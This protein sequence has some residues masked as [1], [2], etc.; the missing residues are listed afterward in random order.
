MTRMGKFT[1]VTISAVALT[2]VLAQTASATS[3]WAKKYGVACTQCHTAFPRLN[4]YGERFMRN[5]YQDPD[6]DVADGNEM[7]KKQINDNLYVDRVT[8]LFGFRLNVTPFGWKA[9][10]LADGGDQITLGNANWIQF[11]VAGSIAKNISFFT[12][13]EFEEGHA[14]FSWYKLRFTNLAGSQMANVEVGNLSPRDYGCYPN[15][16]RIMGPV[17]GDIFGVGSSGGATTPTKALMKESAGN[18]SSAR[19]GVQYYGYKGPVIVWAGVSPGKAIGTQNT[20]VDMD[21]EFNYWGGLRCNLPVAE[22]SAFEGSG[23]SVWG[24]EGTDTAAFGGPG[25]AKNKYS[26]YSVESTIRW[27]SLDIMAAYARGNDDNWNLDATN[28]DID[29]DGVSLVGGYMTTLSNGKGLYYALE[30]DKVMSSD[31]SSLEAEYI[32]PSIS[33]FPIDN[34][35]IGVYARI[36]TKHSSPNSKS[37]A[38][39]NIRTMF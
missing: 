5:G 1:T 36:D 32:T 18:M 8:N 30:Y 34:M 2:M 22:D 35:R 33:Y 13:M 15:R 27:N 12:E 39:M 14:K 26:R 24:L 16:L 11:F 21:S 25:E 29:Y 9:N 10:G 23:I 7:G 3:Q 31:V 20:G 38:F 19:P 4:S 37:T 17:K 6:A 28:M